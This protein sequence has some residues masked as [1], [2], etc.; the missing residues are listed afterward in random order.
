MIGCEYGRIAPENVFNGWMTFEFPIEEM[1]DP[2]AIPSQ[3]MDKILVKRKIPRIKEPRFQVGHLRPP[4]REVENRHVQKID[5]GSVFN[6]K[7]EGLL[8]RFL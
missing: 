6:D 1:T 8:R 7:R 5:A 2:K 3:G 4:C